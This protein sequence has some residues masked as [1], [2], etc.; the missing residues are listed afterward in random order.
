[1]SSHKIK[2]ER[3]SFRVMNTILVMK[4]SFTRIR[5]RQCQRN[6]IKNVKT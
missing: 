2:I 1:M 6:K 3:N 5:N 4:R